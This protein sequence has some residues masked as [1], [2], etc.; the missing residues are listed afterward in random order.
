M[1][2]LVGIEGVIVKPLKQI[3]DNFGTVLHML[4]NDSSLF[5]Q[6]GEVYFSEV[7]TGVI[8]A[9][10]RH[11]KQT[12]NM[13]G[14][15]GKILLVIYDD[16][17]AS[18]TYKKVVKYELGRPEH[19]Q[20]IQIPPMLW[21]GFKGIGKQTSLIANCTDMP[22]DPEEKESLPANSEHVPYQWKTFKKS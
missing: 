17:T 20:L 12:Q 16:R 9:W 18:S 3:E 7:Y 4:R 22:H 8:K 15:L 6:F 10:K 19:Y 11:K 1:N 21:Y 2:G 5:S 13:A 14:P